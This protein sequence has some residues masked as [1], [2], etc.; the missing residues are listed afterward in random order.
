MATKEERAR[1]VAELFDRCEGMEKQARQ[2][3]VFQGLLELVKAQPDDA[4][5][6]YDLA[7][8]YEKGFGGAPKLKAA[9]EC[10]LMAAEGG[11][12]RAQVRVGENYLTGR[13]VERDYV[14]AVRWLTV[15]AS[16]GEPHATHNL[17]VCFEQGLGVAQ[18]YQKAV[19]Y[20]QKAAEAGVPQAE[21]A[22][23]TCYKEGRG[24]P[25]DEAKAREWLRR[26]AMRGHAK[27]KQAL[28]GLGTK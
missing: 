6:Q 17:G 23:G 5:A 7:V 26:A 24:V 11:F 13:G 3:A 28:K 16:Q 2:A 8:C 19:E 4:L 25:K 15:A 9:A 21:Y 1:T 20:Y 22:L 18:N 12:L 14:Q 27:A 10:Y